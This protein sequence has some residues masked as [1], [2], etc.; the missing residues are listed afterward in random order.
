[1]EKNGK[2]TFYDDNG[3]VKYEFEYINKISFIKD[4]KLT[5]NLNINDHYILSEI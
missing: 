4:D 3:N 5:D 2:G 1:M